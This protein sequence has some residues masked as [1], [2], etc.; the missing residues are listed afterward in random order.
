VIDWSVHAQTAILSTGPTAHASTLSFAMVQGA[1]Y[2]AVNAIDRGHR[3]YLRVAPVRRP[4]SQDA[5]AATAAFRVL[6]GLY[7]AQLQ[8]NYD[9]SLA[10][11]GDGDR[12]ARGIAAGE[13]AAAAMLTAR[14]NDGRL[15]AGTP[16]PFQL[17]TSAGAWRVSPPLAAPW[18]RGSP[19]GS[20]HTPPN[21]RAIRAACR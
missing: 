11:I 8:A 15:P 5:A 14:G 1:V 10:A 3:P 19:S 16:Y 13:A 21:C 7:P 4:A 17:G 9:A 6:A 12:K 20:T 18:S 2:D